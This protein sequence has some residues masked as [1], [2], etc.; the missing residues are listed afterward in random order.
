MA[1]P[2]IAQVHGRCYGSG[3]ELML[4]CDLR[5]FA[6]DVSAGLRETALG[7]VPDLGGCARLPAIVGLGRAKDLVLT[8][9]LIDTPEAH[10]IGLADRV[11]PP[12]G[13]EAATA[14]LL[15]ELLRNSTRAIGAAKR[16][17][18][19][20]AKPA[21]STVL[22]LEVTAQELLAGGPDL[23]EGARAA[24]ERRPPRFGTSDH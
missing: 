10:R 12:G 14:A 5:V 18:D 19:A 15:E 3:F 9:R 7:L 16:L 11:A 21:L 1:K 24:M 8:A 20:A 6:D 2:T 17:L 13:L 22:E 4:A 23:A